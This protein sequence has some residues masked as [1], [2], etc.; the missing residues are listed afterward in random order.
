MQLAKPL[1]STTPTARNRVSALPGPVIINPYLYSPV[2][3][4]PPPPVTV[5]PPSAMVHRH[6]MMTASSTTVYP[7]FGSSEQQQHQQQQEETST[8]A[9]DRGSSTA[10]PGQ[11]L[12][13]LD[14][15][16][17]HLTDGFYDA[18]RA[19]RPATARPKP[20]KLDGEPQRFPFTRVCPVRGL[21]GV[22]AR[23]WPREH[24][25]DVL[26]FTEDHPSTVKIEAKTEADRAKW[27]WT[28]EDGKLEPFNSSTATNRSGQ[29]EVVFP[30][31][32]DAITPRGDFPGVKWIS[33]PP[34]IT[35]FPCLYR[36]SV[37]CFELSPFR[38]PYDTFYTQTKK[39]EG[40]VLSLSGQALMSFFKTQQV[41]TSSIIIAAIWIREVHTNFP[42][43]LSVQLKSR[44]HTYPDDCTSAWMIPEGPYCD[45]VIYPMDHHQEDELVWVSSP[46]LETPEFNRWVNVSRTDLE[47]QM[48]EA[49]KVSEKRYYIPGPPPVAIHASNHLQFLALSEWSRILEEAKARNPEHPENL[50]R[51]EGS[52]SEG[53]S[54]IVSQDILD[55]LYK[56]KFEGSMNRGNY[57]MRLD[58]GLTLHLKLKKPLSSSSSSSLDISPS[59]ASTLP[60]TFS[61][62]VGLKWDAFLGSD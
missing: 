41:S 40:L 5:A 19:L 61:I 6:S 43:P 57:L 44:H 54:F 8:T 51:I 25:E 26:V 3:A 21:C 16:L 34:G 53:Y 56:E 62:K 46:T 14:G 18:L 42:E 31:W 23:G 49:L 33:K 55:P 30:R 35:R 52:D 10:A 1:L 29:V 7:Q 13:N 4:P 38:M 32:L 24:E 50:A 28:N 11:H 20:W 45:H 15:T 36:Y 27:G 47:K 2:P 58:H 9:E 48:K 17:T 39:E 37:L 12:L 60:V 59:P 22:Q